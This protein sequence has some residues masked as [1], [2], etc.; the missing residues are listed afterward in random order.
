MKGPPKNCLTLRPF[1]IGI[2][3]FFPE[4]DFLV[5]N[6]HWEVSVTLTFK[7]KIKESPPKNTL[8]RCWS[9]VCVFFTCSPSSY[10]SKY[11][12]Y[13]RLKDYIYE[14]LLFPPL[15]SNHQLTPCVD[16]S[17]TDGFSFIPTQRI[18]RETCI[19]ILSLFIFPVISS[20]QQ[21][22][23][24]SNKIVK[25]FIDLQSALKIQFWC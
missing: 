21:N 22:K 14:N 4:M 19:I 7:E 6:L 8:Q 1:H 12:N 20:L 16:A 3:K 10:Y 2:I 11:W 25:D 24:L 15:N 13:W 17:L 23:E 18:D 9:F 5:I